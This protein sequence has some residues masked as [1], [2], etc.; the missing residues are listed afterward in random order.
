MPLEF[1]G[2]Y[3]YD[4]FTNVNDYAPIHLVTSLRKGAVA[5]YFL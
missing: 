4:T 5:G 3:L 1:S 2:E